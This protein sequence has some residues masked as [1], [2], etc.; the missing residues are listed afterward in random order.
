MSDLKTYFIVNKILNQTKNGK[1]NIGDYKYTWVFHS[2]IF[3]EL[4]HNSLLEHIQYH[5]EYSVS[6]KRRGRNRNFLFDNIRFYGNKAPVM[7]FHGYADE[8]KVE[9]ITVKNFYINDN[10]LESKDQIITEIG[11]FTKNI[12]IEI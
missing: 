4:Y 6:A 5:F 1:V 3:Y 11:D 10:P 9:N 7:K 2:K 12:D 8:F